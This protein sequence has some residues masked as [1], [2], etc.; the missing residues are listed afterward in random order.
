[1]SNII[2]LHHDELITNQEKIDF[3]I[4]MLSSKVD[5]EVLAYLAPDA[6]DKLAKTKEILSNYFG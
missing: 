3:L 6:L 2:C 4:R 1:M 5:I